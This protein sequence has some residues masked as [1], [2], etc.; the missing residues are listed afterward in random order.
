M[1]NKLV[2][3]CWVAVITPLALHAAFLLK[4]AYLWTPILTT[5]PVLVVGTSEYEEFSWWKK[6]FWKEK[7]YSS[8]YNYLLTQTLKLPFCSTWFSIYLSFFFL[9]V[10]VSLYS[11][12]LIPCMVGSHCL[13]FKARVFRAETKNKNPVCWLCWLIQLYCVALLWK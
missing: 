1:T 7:Y 4:L 9:T 8:H 5:H 13:F 12:V 10:Y 6:M 2:V 3:C 11:R